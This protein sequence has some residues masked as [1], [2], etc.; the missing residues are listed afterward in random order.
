[1][2]ADNQTHQS[3]TDTVE[4]DEEL[5][6]LYLP[7]TTVETLESVG[8]G[9]DLSLNEICHRILATSLKTMLVERSI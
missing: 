2:L 9:L 6:T 7:K 8:R 3:T 1:M 5:V 4:A